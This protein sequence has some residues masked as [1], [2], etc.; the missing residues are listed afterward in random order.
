MGEHEQTIVDD[1]VDWL[2]D[3][4]DTTRTAY[5]CENGIEAT[6]ID[7]KASIAEGDSG[8]PVVRS[9]ASGVVPRGIISAGS[10]GTGIAS[11]NATMTCDTDNGGPIDDVR[12]HDAS[13]VCYKNIRYVAIKPLLTYWNVHLWDG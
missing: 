5:A 11:G 8:G 2:C 12:G 1:E 4:N 3:D 6:S 10:D 13:A 7:S 9:A